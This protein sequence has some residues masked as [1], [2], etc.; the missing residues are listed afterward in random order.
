MID[1]TPEARLAQVDLLTKHRPW[2]VRGGSHQTGPW[3]VVSAITP[4]IGF[5]VSAGWPEVQE[6]FCIQL[7]ALLNE[8]SA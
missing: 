2:V 8:D 7:A 4:N 3:R 1:Q 5:S 6:A